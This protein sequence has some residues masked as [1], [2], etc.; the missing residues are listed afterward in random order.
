MPATNTLISPPAW[1][2]SMMRRSAFATQSMFSEPLSSEICAPALSAIHSSGTC[3]F[4]ARSSAAMIRRHSGSATA[5]ISR[6]ASPSRITRRM[7]SG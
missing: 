6:L 5:P 7:P 2:N 3:S 4:S 1:V